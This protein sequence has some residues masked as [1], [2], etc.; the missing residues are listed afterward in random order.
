[1]PF[2][3]SDLL[4][5]GHVPELDGAVPGFFGSE[6]LIIWRK[7]ERAWAAGVRADLKDLP[8][9][10]IEEADLAVPRAGGHALAV[11]RERNAEGGSLYFTERAPDAHVP[12]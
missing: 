1:M 8:C 12:T 7:D 6:D 4:A 11:G 9:P 3:R 10:H 5:R 2:A